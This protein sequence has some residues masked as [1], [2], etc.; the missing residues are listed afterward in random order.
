MNTE[1]KLVCWERYFHIY[2]C[3]N[4]AYGVHIESVQTE[5]KCLWETFCLFY[6][7]GCGFSLNVMR[8]KLRP[9]QTIHRVQ[10]KQTR[11]GKP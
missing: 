8:A 1:R 2:D 6:I 9:V 5:N 11:N 3:L 4:E 7:D 10:T